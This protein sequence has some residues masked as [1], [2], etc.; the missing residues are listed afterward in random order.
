MTELSQHPEALRT[1]MR[2]S[3]AK[4]REAEARARAEAFESTIKSED[5]EAQQAFTR[6]CEF[7]VNLVLEADAFLLWA[8]HPAAAKTLGIP[9]PTHVT[10]DSVDDA[11]AY[12]AAFAEQYDRNPLAKLGNRWALMTRMCIWTGA[13]LRYRVCGCA[14]AHSRDCAFRD[15]VVDSIPIHVLVG[16]RDLY[17]QLRQRLGKEFPTVFVKPA[18]TPVVPSKSVAELESRFLARTTALDKGLPLISDGAGRLGRVFAGGRCMIDFDAFTEAEEKCLAKFAWLKG[19]RTGDVVVDAEME[20]RCRAPKPAP[21]PKPESA[22]ESKP[23]E[24]PAPRPTLP[25]PYHDALVMLQSL[26]GNSN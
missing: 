6:E 7:A 22:F 17:Q 18:T 21:E 11:I 12:V 13:S 24:P 16:T 1:R 14:A 2:R 20:R 26:R 23:P 4:V 15:D 3:V 9:V 19:F 5:F 25:G 10:A 8:L